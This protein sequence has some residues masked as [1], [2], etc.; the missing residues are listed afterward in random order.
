MANSPDGLHRFTPALSGDILLAALTFDRA[1]APHIADAITNLSVEA[2]W[3]EVGDTVAAV[4]TAAAVTVA[5]YYENML[6]GSVFPWLSTPPSGWLL[7]DGS[8]H[9]EEDYPELFAVLDDSL[10]SGSDFTLPDTSDAFP[11]GVQLKANAG[12]VSGSN[13][14]NLTVGQLPAHTHTYTPPVL[15]VDAETPT[16]PIP[17][18]GIGSPIATGSAGDGDDIDRRP[19]RFT[20]IFAVYAGRT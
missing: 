15:T 18:A 3:L 6:V 19:K 8:T 4:V 20:L 13:T 7:L 11:F 2:T 10:K 17:T 1:L 5:D 16:V 12:A 9:A 14:L